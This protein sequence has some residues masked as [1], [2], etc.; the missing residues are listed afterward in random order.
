MPLPVRCSL[1]VVQ[2]WDCHQSGNCCKEYQVAITEEERQRI[3]GQGWAAEPDFRGVPLFRPYGPAWARQHQLNYREDGSCVFLSA[4]GRCR[5]HERFGSAAKPLPCRLFPFIL[6]PAGDH[7]RVGIRF[8]CP[9]AAQ[10]KGRALSA[11]DADLREFAA[12][13]E[14]REGVDQAPGPRQVSPP[15][16]QGRQAVEWPDLFRFIEALQKLLGNRSDRVERRLRKCLALANLCRQANFDTLK[17]QRLGEL[18]DLLT[19]GLEGEVPAD[20]AEVGRPGWTGRLLFRLALALYARKD[21]G[22]NRGPA[23]FGR[24]SLLSAAWRYA[25]GRGEAPRLHGRS[26]HTTFEK[27][28]EP[29]GP[30]PAD[31]EAVLERYYLI[32]VGSLQ[33]CGVTNFDMPVWEGLESLLLTF[34]ILMWLRRGLADLPPAAALTRALSIVDDN[35]G[36]HQALGTGRQRLALRILARTGDLE[37]LIA[38]YG[39]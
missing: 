28:E 35:F 39:R 18:L 37:R 38:W 5:I 27:A 19:A 15:A 34:P 26:P 14:R 6:V 8:A 29:G 9:S 32:K 17:G 3:E 21:R 24:L 16:L 11:H 4:E 23:T 36:Y 13:L 31:A 30:L 1:P 20:P 25:R 7:Y 22:P 33:F 2:N 12:Q 10:N